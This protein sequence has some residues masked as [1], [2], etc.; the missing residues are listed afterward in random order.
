MSGL[1]LFFR[2]FWTTPVNPSLKIPES[3]RTTDEGVIEGSDDTDTANKND[4]TAIPTIDSTSDDRKDCDDPLIVHV[5][6][7]SNG[8][9]N[10]NVHNEYDQSLLF[11]VP[12]SHII[13]QQLGGHPNDSNLLSTTITTTFSPYRQWR[14]EQCR[15]VQDYIIRRLFVPILNAAAAAAND[16]DIEIVDQPFEVTAANNKHSNRIASA[17]GN[18]TEPRGIPQELETQIDIPPTYEEPQQSPLESQQLLD[19]SPDNNNDNRNSNCDSSDLLSASNK[20]STVVNKLNYHPLHRNVPNVSETYFIAAHISEIDLYVQQLSI[21]MAKITKVWNIRCPLE[22]RKHMKA[23]DRGVVSEQFQEDGPLA[24]A[25]P[26]VLT[27]E[28]QQSRKESC[29]ELR[30]HTEQIHTVSELWDGQ[31]I[32]S[33]DGD[34]ISHGPIIRPVAEF[35]KIFW[36]GTY[37]TAMNTIVHDTQE[38]LQPLKLPRIKNTLGKLLPGVELY[39][40]LDNVPAKC[41]FPIQMVDPVDTN[42]NAK[43]TKT[44]DWYDTYHTIPYCLCIGGESTMECKNNVDDTLVSNASEQPFPVNGSNNKENDSSTRANPNR[45]RFDTNIDLDPTTSPLYI[46]C[47]AVVLPMVSNTND[48]HRRAT[49]AVATDTASTM[50]PMIIEYQLK[51]G[52]KLRKQILE[53]DSNDLAIQTK[54]QSVWKTIQK[55]HH[56]KDVPNNTT[57]TTTPNATDPMDDDVVTTTALPSTTTSTLDETI[58]PNDTMNDTNHESCKSPQTEN[59]TE[60]VVDATNLDEV[61]T[62]TIPISDPVGDA[63]ANQD[64]TRTACHDIVASERMKKRPRTQPALDVGIQYQKLVR[65]QRNVVV[66]RYYVCI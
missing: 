34:G 53:W 31:E 48:V 43:V 11:K 21:P 1:A 59:I 13:Q 63:L 45:I 47:W 3:A 42:S 37:A 2:K 5:A 8:T 4:D 18:N 49:T 25:Y 56:G 36:Y 22:R 28:I 15:V 16:D 57:T 38:F 29:K 52:H 64:N 62:A 7:G 61:N 23:G 9:T 55:K 6:I 20:A 14:Q 17:T 19:N 32:P 12:N 39:V 41:I 24:I 10:D 54:M 60:M 30:R 27:M 46:H 50:P 26:T 35:A 40:S 44:A 33:H 65:T 51:M 58:R 66:A